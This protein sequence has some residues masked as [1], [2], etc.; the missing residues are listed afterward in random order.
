[1]LGNSAAGSLHPGRGRKQRTE[2]C[3]AEFIN[4]LM[5]FNKWIGFV[6]NSVSLSFPLYWLI[7]PLLINLGFGANFQLKKHW[8]VEGF[9]TSI[10]RRAGGELLLNVCFLHAGEGLFHWFVT[11]CQLEPC[12]FVSFK[13]L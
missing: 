7:P 13:V 6:L 2:I 9:R 4:L 10:A 3:K 1:M 11:C 5:C 8:E 12:S